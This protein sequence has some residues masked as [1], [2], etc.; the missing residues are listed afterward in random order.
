MSKKNKKTANALDMRVTDPKTGK[1][2]KG[3]PGG[4]LKHSRHTKT[5]LSD[6]IGA[7]AIIDLIQQEYEKAKNGD[8][9][10][11]RFLISYWLNKPATEPSLTYF[12]PWEIGGTTTVQEILHEASRI[13]IALSNGEISKEHAAEL[14]VSLRDNTSMIAHLEWEPFIEKMLELKKRGQI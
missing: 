4:A 12:E 2:S 13:T 3:N 11:A 7:K 10:A 9:E 14:R 5:I 8:S 1:F 6:A